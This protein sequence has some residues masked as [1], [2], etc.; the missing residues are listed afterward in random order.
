[1]KIVIGLGNVGAPYQGTRHNIGFRVVDL[2]AERARVGFTPFPGTERV[3]W[4]S[5]ALLGD[6]TV[7]LAKPRTLMN[8]SGRAAQALAARFDAGPEDLLVVYDDADL[9]LGR[10]RLRPGGG[11]GGH[12]GIRSLLDVLKVD[13]FGRLRLGVRGTGRDDADLADYVLHSF[14][15]E[16]RTVVEALVCLGADAAQAAVREGIAAA[17]NRF[18]GQIALPATS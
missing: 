9:A 7:V 4:I 13:S 18:N 16:E 6:E 1:M 3:A 10:V 14:D 11:A 5:E 17:M 2:L 12:N 8:G 15:P